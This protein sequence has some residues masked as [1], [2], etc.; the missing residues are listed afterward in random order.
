M[1]PRSNLTQA[2]TTSPA[3]VIIDTVGSFN[4]GT[5]QLEIGDWTLPG[6]TDRDVRLYAATGQGRAVEWR[7]NPATA[8]PYQAELN[9]SFVGLIPPLS[10]NP[11]FT[12]LAADLEKQ[13]L[14]SLPPTC[15]LLSNWGQA[16]SLC[17]ATGRGVETGRPYVLLDLAFVKGTCVIPPATE[18]EDL[19]LLG[20]YW[21]PWQGADG[22]FQ[23]L[24]LTKDGDIR[25]DPLNQMGF[26][27]SDIEI[28][29]DGQFA[30][31][32]ASGGVFV[33]TLNY[34][35]AEE[36][37]TGSSPG[38]QFIR[39]KAW[40]VASTRYTEPHPIN[41]ELPGVDQPFAPLTI[42]R[43]YREVEGAAWLGTDQVVLSMSGEGNQAAL[44]LYAFGHHSKALGVV[45]TM[46][47][48]VSGGA[49]NPV[50]VDIPG[51]DYYV[52]GRS[53]P[54][55]RAAGDTACMQPATE[56]A[57]WWNWRSCPRCRPR[58]TRCWPTSQPS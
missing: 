47:E 46:L 36:L 54:L 19:L 49:A 25:R 38:E 53:S 39:D 33:V 29:P 37:P 51:T 13:W 40:M 2:R 48:D 9:P 56:T 14:G 22:E 58:S 3:R 15:K 57:P 44:V 32:T 7:V 43:S 42:V 5:E 27:I 4:F 30:L 45:R 12:S 11:A 16:Y 41:P 20:R 8:R 1:S 35:D 52:G 18:P 6:A 34:T 55:P 24:H 10:T 23:V 31:V 28:S 26:D 50:P 17:V 21:L